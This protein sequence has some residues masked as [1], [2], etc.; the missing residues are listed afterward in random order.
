MKNKAIMLEITAILDK[1]C[2]NCD[3]KIAIRKHHGSSNEQ[4]YCNEIC[5]TGRELREKGK[6]LEGLDGFRKATDLTPEKY[7]FLK[8]M[9]YFDRDICKMYGI[10]LNTLTRRKKKWGITAPKEITYEKYK[11]LKD[12]GYT[13]KEICKALKIGHVTLVQLKKKWGILK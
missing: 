1:F 10:G 11:N 13:D 8:R 4:R 3:V 5:Q 9:G 2:A 6:Q 12:R 7:E